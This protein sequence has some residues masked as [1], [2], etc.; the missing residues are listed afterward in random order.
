LI[1]SFAS[2]HD[3]VEAVVWLRTLALRKGLDS[4][5]DGR[6]ECKM[7]DQVCGE[8]WVTSM[9]RDI[10]ST[11]EL[12]PGSDVTGSAGMVDQDFGDINA[13]TEGPD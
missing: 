4:G 7:V 12:G 9:F 6:R 2:G 8:P 1:F 11:E 10:G 3:D 5:S 13:D